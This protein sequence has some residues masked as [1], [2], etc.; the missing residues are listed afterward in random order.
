MRQCRC[1]RGERKKAEEKLWN[2]VKKKEKENEN[3][4]KFRYQRTGNM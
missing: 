4:V 2:N 1:R 3:K